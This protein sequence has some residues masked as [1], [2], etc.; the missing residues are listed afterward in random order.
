MFTTMY[1]NR[2]AA[3]E[4]PQDPTDYEDFEDVAPYNLLENGKWTSLWLKPHPLYYPIINRFSS[5]YDGKLMWREL[6][7]MKEE[8]EKV[9]KS[10]DDYY[11]EVC[12]DMKKLRQTIR[13]QNKLCG[14]ECAQKLQ[15]HLDTCTGLD[16][17]Y[18]CTETFVYY[19]CQ[20]KENG[21]CSH[22]YEIK[23][24][25]ED[26]EHYEYYDHVKTSHLIDLEIEYERALAV[27]E[28]R[29]KEYEDA[30]SDDDW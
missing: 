25:E 12:D 19:D 1:S 14:E 28:G 13:E 8:L 29:L 18:A 17:K 20:F 3:L 5:R 10:R 22:Y 2:F 30:I 23:R 9:R 4:I 26:L 27:K 6:N 11:R 7:E 15:A 21:R 24:A 16:G